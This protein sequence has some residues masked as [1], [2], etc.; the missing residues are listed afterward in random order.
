MPKSSSSS[1]SH[2]H[3]YSIGWWAKR[4]FP[5]QFISIIIITIYNHSLPS[6]SLSI[7]SRIKHVFITITTTTTISLSSIARS[8]WSEN[9]TK[10]GKL[11]TLIKWRLCG[12]ANTHHS[13]TCCCCLTHS[14]VTL[15][16]TL[17]GWTQGWLG[18][19]YLWW[20]MKAKEF[21]VNNWHT[22]MMMM[23]K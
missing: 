18:T 8:P 19:F 7:P 13:H 5:I 22:K 21:K 9:S 16:Y 20:Q 23:I 6:S 15:T 10:T 3:L 4:F 12:K 1:T 11:Y 14:L 2:F 17:F